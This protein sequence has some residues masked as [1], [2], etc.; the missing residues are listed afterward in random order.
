[1]KALYTSVTLM[2]WLARDHGFNMVEFGV[3]LC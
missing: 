1:M 3:W 2:D